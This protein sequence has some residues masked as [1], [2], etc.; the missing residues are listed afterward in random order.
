MFIFF[1]VAK[2]Y[3][4]FRISNFFNLFFTFEA[5]LFQKQEIRS[6]KRHFDADIDADTDNYPII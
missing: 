3:N 5:K 2:I 1:R 6:K 4:D